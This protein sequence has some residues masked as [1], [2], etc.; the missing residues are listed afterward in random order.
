MRLK[1]SEIEIIKATTKSFLSGLSYTLYLFGSRTD[2]TKKGGDIDLLLKFNS[3][4]DFESAYERKNLLKFELC[5]A[6]G[7]QRVDVV[8]TT[9]ERT[10]TDLFLQSIQDDLIQL[11][12]NSVSVN[13]TADA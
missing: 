6:L 11:D 10:Q 12:H 8:L 3:K 2:N 9:D 5:H 1:S 4:S 7:D 13:S